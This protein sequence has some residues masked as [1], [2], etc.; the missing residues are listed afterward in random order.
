M[1]QPFLDWLPDL[2]V[3]TFEIRDLASL[4]IGGLG[5]FL[6]YLAIK[7]GKEQAKGGKRL[8]KLTADLAA[9]QFRLKEISEQ[10]HE[11]LWEQI[12]RKAILSL[13][14][15]RMYPDSGVLD[16]TVNYV[17][18]VTNT[19]NKICREFLWSLAL[20]QSALPFL[21]FP[22]GVEIHDSLDGTFP[23]RRIEGVFA[24]TL[25]PGQTS[26]V[27]SFK[28][29]RAALLEKDS[30]SLQI[31]WSILSDDGR[32]PSDTTYGNFEIARGRVFTT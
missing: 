25:F 10:Q 6:A 13:T 16:V 22:K 21:V 12:R 15:K 11:Y 5:A 1:W 3:G 7:L 19:G 9:F 32:F 23:V 31:L 28:V 30:E 17:V 18:Q 29:Q 24:K 26:V 2:K 27:T 8:E 20:P 14:H 4:I